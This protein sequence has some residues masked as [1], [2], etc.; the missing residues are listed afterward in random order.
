[1]AYTYTDTYTKNIFTHTD[2]WT[3]HVLTHTYMYIYTWTYRY[4]LILI[5]IHKILKMRIC[6]FSATFIHS[7]VPSVLKSFCWEDS[8]LPKLKCFLGHHQMSRLT[9]FSEIVL[10]TKC[11]HP[12]TNVL[13]KRKKKS[14]YYFSKVSLY[15]GWRGGS[16]VKSTCFSFIFS[17][18][19]LLY[20]STL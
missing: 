14:I 19:Y 5:M 6:E 9:S 17:C 8:S 1:M 2:T 15:R 7:R 10:G 11:F 3:W 18:I 16:M 12:G 13:M 20:V 4:T